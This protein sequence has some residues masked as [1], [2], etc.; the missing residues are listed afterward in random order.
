M[1][2]ILSLSFILSFA[3]ATAEVEEVFIGWNAFKC[4]NNCL[5]LIETNFSKIED[6]TQL[7]INA[8]AGQAEMQWNPNKPFSYE[9]FRSAAAAV[10]I[11]IREMRL[12]VKG[13]IEHDLDSFYLISTTDHTRFKLIAP[14]QTESGRYTPRYNLSNHYFSNEE[15]KHLLN[16]ENQQKTVIVSGLLYLPASYTNILIAEKIKPHKRVSDN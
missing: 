5:E 14:I 1:K 16:L 3:F 13:T 6:K 12:R 8:A 11:T 7:K 9:P 4:Q 10:G 15:K 2:I